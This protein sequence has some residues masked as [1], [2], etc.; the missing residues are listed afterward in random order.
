MM[1]NLLKVTSLLAVL[2]M[3]LLALTG[4][5][6]NKIVGTMEDDESKSKIEATFDKDDNLK[7]LVITA[8][9]KKTEDAKDAYESAKDTFEFGKVKRSGK[10]V[11]V[12]IKAK[13]L[14]ENSGMDEDKLDKDTVKQLIEFMGFE[15]KD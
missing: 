12:T 14:A 8:K 5:G 1:K 9:Y 6:G 2:V 4:C 11:T 13:D 15:I 3:L 10:K 7:Q